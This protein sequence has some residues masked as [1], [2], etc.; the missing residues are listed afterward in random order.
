MFLFAIFKD[1]RNSV[2]RLADSYHTYKTCCSL[3]IEVLL[4]KLKHYILN[5]SFQTVF[6]ANILTV[7]FI[8]QRDP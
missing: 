1:A 2:F 8:L 7:R 6:S 4:V 5:T 3:R